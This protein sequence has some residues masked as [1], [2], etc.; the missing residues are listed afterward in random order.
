MKNSAFVAPEYADQSLKF[1]T[2]EI[3]TGSNILSAKYDGGHP[4]KQDFLNLLRRA[5]LLHFAGHSYSHPSNLDSIFL[6]LGDG[7]DTLYVNDL[8]S[9][10]ASTR[11]AVLSSCHSATGTPSAEGNVGLAYG[12]AFAGTPNVISSLWAV[13]DRESAGIF[14]HYYTSLKSGTNSSESLRI[15]KLKYLEVAPTPAQHPYFWAN[16]VYYG[17]PVRYE[18]TGLS[19]LWILIGALC[20]GVVGF[21]FFKRH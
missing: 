10:E 20:F 12:L 7:D 13:S 3:R 11:L 18:P 1:H 16:W 15:A 17:H 5:D 8:L 14:E 9:T 2:A 21:L 6:L 4:Q 19:Y